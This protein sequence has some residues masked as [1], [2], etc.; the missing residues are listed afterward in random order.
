MK[1]EVF[2]NSIFN[3]FEKLF[4]KKK[5]SSIVTLISDEDDEE[6]IIDN[7]IYL[8]IDNEH[9]GIRIN[10]VCPDF[11]KSFIEDIDM[12][13]LYWNYSSIKTKS[14]EITEFTIDSIRIIFDATYAELLGFFFCDK[15]NKHSFSIILMTD[16][17]KMFENISF[18]EYTN[19]VN[20]NLLHI[21][22]KMSFSI[23]DSSNG[24]I[25][26]SNDFS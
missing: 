4:F 6:Q 17:L 12:F 26:N 3:K 25:K 19:E 9:V 5:I 1:E 2:V 18:N 10:G 7:V 15:L 23:D 24:W 11:T 20:N 14:K 22:N 21:K 16:E 13:N 8:Q